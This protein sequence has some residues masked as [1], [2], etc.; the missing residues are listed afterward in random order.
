MGPG[1]PPAAYAQVR[2][3][4]AADGHTVDAESDPEE[5]VEGVAGTLFP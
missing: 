1:P 3:P 5:P 4:E 2:T